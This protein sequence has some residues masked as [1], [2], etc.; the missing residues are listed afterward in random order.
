MSQRIKTFVGSGG[1][2]GTGSGEGSER[3]RGEEWNFLDQDFCRNKQT[4]I[5]E[6]EKRGL[7]AR[8]SVGGGGNK[9]DWRLEFI[10][11]TKKN[12]YHWNGFLI[13]IKAR[14]GNGRG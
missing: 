10:D 12:F 2:K 5:C 7:S 4:E 11:E 14:T 3:S 13:L 8:G 1:E 6:Y 9:K